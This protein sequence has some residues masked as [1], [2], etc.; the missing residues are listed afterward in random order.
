M[1]SEVVLLIKTN[2][3][4]DTIEW[5]EYYKKLGFDHIT[6]YDNE[7]PVDIES[8]IKQYNNISYSKMRI[9]VQF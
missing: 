2:Y 7:S 3:Y 6:I 1:T 8:L 4:Y 9:F 5:I